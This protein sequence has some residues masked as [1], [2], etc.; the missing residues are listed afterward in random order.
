L[1]FLRAGEEKTH[2]FSAFS[3]LQK[4]F[5]FVI[6]SRFSLSPNTREIDRGIPGLIRPKDPGLQFLPVNL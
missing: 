4:G 6:L 5:Q 3:Q 1:K 2:V